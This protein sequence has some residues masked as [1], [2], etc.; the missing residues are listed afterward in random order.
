MSRDAAS[1][2]A[3]LLERAHRV[4]VTRADPERSSPFAPSQMYD[5][6]RFVGPN[7]FGHGEAL[8]RALALDPDLRDSLPEAVATHLPGHW[9]GRSLGHHGQLVLHGRTHHQA[10][11]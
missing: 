9:V 7:A 1:V 5:A 8:S 2:L 11:S 4:V 6:S 3:P 10:D